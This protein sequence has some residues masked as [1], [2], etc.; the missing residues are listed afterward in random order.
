MSRRLAAGSRLV[1]ASHNRGKLREIAALLAP[2]RIDALAAHALGLPEP[3]E[4]ESDFVG[5]ARLKAL[6]A[7]R[8]ANMPALADD[9][10]FCVAALG[11]APGVL[12]A[13]WAGPAR[14]FS[15][16]MQ[17]V[18]DEMGAASD[19]RAWFVCALCLAWPD[20]HAESFVGRVDGTVAWPPRGNLGFGY[21]P[22]FL[23]EGGTLTYGEMPPEEKHATSH[24]ARA[25][26]Q[27]V[28]ACLPEQDQDSA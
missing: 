25:F 15:A 9:S 28:A 8:G 2:F 11:G 1:L 17:R 6:A 20:G 21:D 26:A 3:E 22:I 12:S 5:N 13:R 27:L 16:A 18:H 24:R 4:T 14:D 10:G 23:P 19:R 7:A